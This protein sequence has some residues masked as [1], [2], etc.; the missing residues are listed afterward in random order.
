M[1]S[2]TI[3]SITPEIPPSVNIAIKPVAQSIGVSIFKTP[4][5]SVAIHEKI[6]IPVGIAMIAVVIII[7][8]RIQSDIPET[9]M[10]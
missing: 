8:I 2:G 4:R 5:Q 10:W 7:G 6:L 3:A 9:N 1:S